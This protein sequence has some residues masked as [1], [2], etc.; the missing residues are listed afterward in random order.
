MVTMVVMR[1]LLVK[2]FIACQRNQ[3]E[4]SCD[5]AKK[6]WCDFIFYCFVLI[7]LAPVVS[8]LSAFHTLCINW[9]KMSSITWN[10]SRWYFFIF[11]PHLGIWSNLTNIFQMGGSTT[12]QLRY[13]IH[14]SR[15]QLRDCCCCAAHC[16][17]A[18]VW[19]CD[20][21]IPAVGL[22]A[23]QRNSGNHP[24]TYPCWCLFPYEI[25]TTDEDIF[26]KLTLYI[27]MF[28]V[29]GFSFFAGK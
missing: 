7:N 8:K 4:S 13:E 28:C 15:Q 12:H 1:C 29:D 14:F 2:G 17:L 27:A 11:T 18:A 26:F 25:I 22:C 23:F 9:C 6:S 10:L 24:T 3:L 16:H 20:C 21:K 5:L 19:N